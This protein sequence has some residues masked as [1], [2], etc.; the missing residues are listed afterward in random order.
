MNWFLRLKLA[1]KLTVLVAVACAFT[2]GVGA[3]GLAQSARIGELLDGTYNNNLKSVEALGEASL[4]HSAHARSYVRLPSLR[5]PSMVKS[6]VE[7]AKTHWERLSDALRVYRSLPLSDKETALLHQFDAVAPRY[8]EQSDKLV[9]LVE[10]ARFE[11]AAVF[12]NGD[13]RKVVTE[14]EAVLVAL[15]EENSSQ[16]KKSFVASQLQIAEARTLTIGA[17]VAAV[18]ACLLFGVWVTRV[19]TRQI[20][21]EPD[22]AL[23]VVRAV[24]DGDLTTKVVVRTGDQTSLLAAM[25]SMIE[26]LT[27]VIG[28]VRE[29]ADAL[30]ASSE[31]L[32]SS[33]E[34]LSQNASEQAA[35]VEET[36][37]S[38]EEISSTVAQNSENAKVTD[39][40]AGKSARDAKEGGAAV[41][42]T[43]EAMKQIAAKIGIVDDIA[44][45]TNLLALN[46]AI[47][48]ARAGEHG[49][50]FAVVAVEVRKLAERSQ[51]AAQEI[52]ALADNSVSLAERAGALFHEIIPSITRT[53]DL[54][55]EIASASREQTSGIEQ[56]TTAMTQVSQTTQNNAS[57]SEELSS[58]ATELSNRALQLKDTI[59]FFRTG[60]AQ[61][62]PARSLVTRPR[63][64]R[65]LPRAG[66]A[67]LRPVASADAS[68]AHFEPF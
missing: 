46:A 6:V 41:S 49:K 42:Q 13:L 66:T 60:I 23:A 56:V 68:D 2:A 8:L 33:A 18:V 25:A 53:A 64:Q 29:S 45:Q 22:Y 34:L 63:K 7:R 20:G 48:A 38:M 9:G 31:E 16:A 15:I 36:S 11:E 43:V 4:A 54:V 26:R 44:Y 58:T 3:Y 59:E 19:L 10:A 24:A 55:Q 1:Q 21:G 12:G 28:E 32:T 27:K 35:S 17:I 50:G 61:E 39:A 47:E 37:S 14:V 5:E 67:R 40:M 52:G 51:V 65:P 62:A 30:A 57:A